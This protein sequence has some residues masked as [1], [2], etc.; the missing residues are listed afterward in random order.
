MTKRTLG[1]KQQN[2]DGTSGSLL[3]ASP[4][5]TEA[6]AQRIVDTLCRVRGMLDE[7]QNQRFFI[8]WPLY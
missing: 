7:S 2:G 5:L 4:F 1:L 6:N 3:D 8:F